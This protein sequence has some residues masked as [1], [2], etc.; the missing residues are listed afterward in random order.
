MSSNVSKPLFIK[1]ETRPL[2]LRPDL[3][4][5]T[6]GVVLMLGPCTVENYEQTYVI[7]Q[8]IHA[9]GGRVLRGGA[10]KPRTS[11][12]SFQGLGEPGLKILRT[13]ADEFHLLVITEALSIAQLPVVLE[14]ADIIQIGSRNMHH[15]PLLSA[16]GQAR[17]P[18]LLKRSFMATI[19]E[20]LLA[21]EYIAAQGND[22]IMLCE[23]GIR[24]FDQTTRFTFD[25]NAIAIVKQYSPYPIFGDPSHATG[26]ADLVASA[27]RAAIAAGADGLLIEVHPHPENA[28]CDGDQAVTLEQLPQF[29]TQ[30]QRIAAAVDRRIG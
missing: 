23:R 4:V 2:T 16:V 28:L 17:K 13:I 22:Q 29:I 21:A 6:D 14:Y 26:R 25:T 24:S 3:H 1:Q 18:V 11:P 15:Y 5:G 27:S 7:A 9:L 10:F 30:L 20:W 12:Y 8:A 19:E